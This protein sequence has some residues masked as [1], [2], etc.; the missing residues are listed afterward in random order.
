MSL[1]IN[2][3]DLGNLRKGLSKLQKRAL[4]EVQ[5]TAM[6]ATLQDTQ[7]TVQRSLNK[8][9]DKPN[10]FTQSAVG[11]TVG[12]LGSTRISKNELAASLAAK[13]IEN[14]KVSRAFISIQENQARYLESALEGQTLTK[15]VAMMVACL[16]Y[17]RPKEG[18]K[19]RPVCRS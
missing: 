18:S 19:V 6:V 15:S 10:K 11:F 4:P 3:K 13:A 12:R 14:G 17:R 2:I 7:R 8:S 16:I 9:L 1:S 5:A